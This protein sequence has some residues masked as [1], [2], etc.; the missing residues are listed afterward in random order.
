MLFGPLLVAGLVLALIALGDR[1]RDPAF[2]VAQQRLSALDAEAVEQAVGSA[3]EP[4]ADAG[5]RPADSTRCT[6]GSGRTELRNPWRCVA[7][8][9]SGETIRYSVVIEPDGE[10]RAVSGDGVRRVIGRIALGG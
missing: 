10:F 7:R 6:P 8:Y 3:E 9:P 5:G 4:R 1:D 2:A